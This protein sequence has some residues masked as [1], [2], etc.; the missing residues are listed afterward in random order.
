M[1]YLHKKNLKT[2]NGPKLSITES[3]TKKRLKIVEEARKVFG[4]GNDWSM[5]GIAYC[6]FKGKKQAIIKLS[7]ISKI[8]FS[9]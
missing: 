5:K 4:F 6:L 1:I 9:S 8:R 3:L 2:S 7:Y